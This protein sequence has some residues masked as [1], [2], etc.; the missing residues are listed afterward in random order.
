M[1]TVA[2]QNSMGYIVRKTTRSSAITRITMT[3]FILFKRL[4]SETKKSYQHNTSKLNSAIFLN[5]A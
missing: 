5:R 3:Y 1:D 2:K 4:V